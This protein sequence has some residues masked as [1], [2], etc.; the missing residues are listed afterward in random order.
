M[1]L[2]IFFLCK[3]DKVNV[4]Q[5]CRS[6]AIH[7]TVALYSWKQH[8][9]KLFQSQFLPLQLEDSECYKFQWYKRSFSFTSRFDSETYRPIIGRWWNADSY[10]L[11]YTLGPCHLH[12]QSKSWI[13]DQKLQPILWDYCHSKAWLP[14]DLIQITFQ[15]PSPNE[16]LKIHEPDTFGHWAWYQR[17]LHWASNYEPWHWMDY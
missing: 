17:Q 6:Q 15:Q 3:S 5:R 9:L 14:L 2:R 1:L 8:W 10:P 13:T 16:G 7:I 12:L 11:Y 4:I